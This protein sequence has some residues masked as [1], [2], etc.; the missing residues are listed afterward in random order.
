MEKH[1]S[2]MPNRR[3]VGVG[4][5]VHLKSQWERQ[6]KKLTAF[7]DGMAGMG[8]EMLNVLQAFLNSLNIK[9]RH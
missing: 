3:E 2:W 7:S 9:S 8:R 5:S 4:I 6:E 1:Y